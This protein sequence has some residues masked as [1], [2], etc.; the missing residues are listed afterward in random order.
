MGPVGVEGGGMSLETAVG[1]LTN[2]LRGLLDQLR[3]VLEQPLNDDDEEEEEQD[4]N[5]R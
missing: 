3:A 4:S 5:D 1:Q 2:S